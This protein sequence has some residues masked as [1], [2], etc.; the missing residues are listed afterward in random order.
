MER[1]LAE[2]RLLAIEGKLTDAVQA[3]VAAAVKQH[4]EAAQKELAMLTQSDSEEAAIAQITFAS[5]LDA[6]T[7]AFTYTLAKSDT[8]SSSSVAVTDALQ[9]AKLATENSSTTPSYERLLAEVENETTRAYEL[10]ESLV[11]DGEVIHS[12]IQRR[13]DDVKRKL[14]EAI[15]IMS[16]STETAAIQAEESEEA[17]EA[18]EI[19]LENEQIEVAVALVSEL[20]R[21]QTAGLLLRE[22]LQTTQKLILFMTD[23]ELASRVSVEELVP[24]EPTLL[25]RQSALRQ[26]LAAI[27]PKITRLVA[28]AEGMTDEKIIVMVDEVTRLKSEITASTE[29]EAM[30]AGGETALVRLEA[31]AL[32]LEKR[33][34]VK[35]KKPLPVGVP[36]T[37]SSTA[38]STP[39]VASTTESRV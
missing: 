11:I 7:E 2:A 29:D 34:E 21:R 32:D 18:E 28:K 4:S 36:I 39:V 3:N 5:S 38:T 35:A 31:V 30:I 26:A 8:R 12:D 9:I 10:L 25:E 24:V 6:Q 19:E 27:K 23:I 20:E 14:A 17:E 1:R 15:A 16:T 13:L 33:L 22:A 37:A